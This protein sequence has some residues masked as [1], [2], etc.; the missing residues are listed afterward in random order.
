MVPEIWSPGDINFCHFGSVFAHLPHQQAAKSKSRK[1]KKTP[2][3]III[4]HMCAIND[5]HIYGS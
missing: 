5:N 3:D 1:I 4:F 2:G